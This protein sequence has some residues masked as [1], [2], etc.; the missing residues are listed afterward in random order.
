MPK[1]YSGHEIGGCDPTV[2]F[3]DLNMTGKGHNAN[4]RITTPPYI[5]N[6]GHMMRIGRQAGRMTVGMGAAFLLCFSFLGCLKGSLSRYEPDADFI[7]LYA[8]LKVASQALNQD[9]DKAGEIRRVILAQ[10]GMTPAEFHEHFMQLADHPEAWRPFQEQ[11]VA[12][13][14]TFQPKPVE[15]RKE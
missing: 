15:T 6:R 7:D 11:V 14:E 1:V 9:L 8:E 10:H 3:L 5:A 13:I 4:A 12:R 2:S